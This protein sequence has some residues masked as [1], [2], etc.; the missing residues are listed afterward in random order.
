MNDSDHPAAR[1][2]AI[3]IYATGAAADSLKVTIGSEDALVR[4]VD[5]TTPG[6]IQITAVVPQNVAPGP[7]VPVRLTVGVAQSQ[8][9]VTIVVK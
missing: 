9:G 2:A 5:P 3:Q 8:E 7:A 4:S 6:V 1:G